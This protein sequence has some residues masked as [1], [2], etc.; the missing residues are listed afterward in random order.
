MREEGAEMLKGW[1][2][3]SSLV[4]VWAIVQLLLL[5][6]RRP[7]SVLSMMLTSFSPAVPVYVVAYSVTPPS[8]G[9]LPPGLS[10]TP[11]LL[12]MLDGALIL[13]LLFA[14]CALFYSHVHNSITLRLLAAFERAPRNSMTL[15]QIEAVSGLRVLVTERVE[16]LL[17]TR[18]VFA[19]RGRY[20]PT[21]SGRLAARAGR[22]V[23]SIMKLRA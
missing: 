8:L 13:V 16:F 2:L 19:D 5:Q 1:I 15:P 21:A 4:L 18:L 6:A 9:I 3:S 17:G 11:P 14:T 7:R 20:Y 12:G 23:R 22:L 10:A